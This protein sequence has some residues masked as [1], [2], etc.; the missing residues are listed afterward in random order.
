MNK[1]PRSIL[2]IQTAFIGDL[3]MSTPLFEGL[4]KIY[5]E[6]D[7]DVVVNSRYISMLSNNPH[8]R[9]VYGFDKSKNKTLNLLRLIRVIRKNRYGLAVSM[10]RH[11]S[12]SLMMYLGGIKKRVGASRQWLLS[13]PV[14]FPD[15][16]HTRERAGLLLQMVEKG[17]YDLQTRLYPSKKDCEDAAILLKDNSRF[18]LGVAPGS[19]WETK[20]WPKGYYIETMRRIGEEA[21]IYVIGGGKDDIM[22]CEEIVEKLNSKNVVNTAGLLSLLGS[23]ALIGQLDLVLCN[24]SAPLHMANAMKTPVFAFFGP[25]VK[26]FGCY[27]YQPYDKML[28]IDLYCRPCTKHGSKLCP[29]GHFRCMKEV[30]PQRVIK[31]I[32]LYMKKY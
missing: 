16:M 14:A 21:D 24:D 11:L 30:E 23:A 8:I 19:V 22:L 1:Q 3:I 2:V 31:E 13:H 29:E 27:P 10:Q 28:E 9:E 20:K 26:R 18:R 25:T 5:P 12:S 32:L 6:A 17:T 4:R 15:G 7:I